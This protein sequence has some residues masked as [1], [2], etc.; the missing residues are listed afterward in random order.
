MCAIW[1]E[2]IGIEARCSGREVIRKSVPK[3][4]F[5]APVR[6]QPVVSSC[7]LQMFERTAFDVIECVRDV[8]CALS[9]KAVECGEEVGAT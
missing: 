9:R 7:S 3:G 6:V 4:L 5:C 8:L 2:H 1:V